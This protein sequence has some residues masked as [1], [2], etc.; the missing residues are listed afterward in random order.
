MEDFRNGKLIVVVDD[1][2]RENEGDL[3]V[4]A[5]HVTPAHVAFMIQYGRGPVH[6]SLEASRLDELGVVTG[7]NRRALHT[8]AGTVAIQARTALAAATGP[9]AQVATIQ[10]AL[11]PS[12]TPGDILSPGDVL[13]LRARPGGV[14]DR[15]GHTEVA[16]DLAKLAGVYPGG[17]LSTLGAAG[18]MNRL[19][20]LEAFAVEHGLTIISIAQVIAHRQRT[21]TLVERVAETK[22]PSRYGEF[23]MIAFKSV[24]DPDEHVALVM[25]DLS[26]DEPVLVRVHSEC[27]T[28]DAFGSLRCDCGEQMDLSLRRIAA[29][30]RGV[31]L[32]MRQE[33]RGIGLHNKIKAYALQ[34]QGLD[35]V[36]ANRALGFSA[37]P[38]QYGVGAQI[39]V[40]LGL[41]RIRLLTNNPKKRVGIE[42]YGLEVV[43][44]VPIIA[45]VTEHNRLYIETKRDKMGHDMGDASAQS[46]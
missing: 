37:D 8:A 5:Q 38:R 44:Q 34:D 7:Q 10:A 3:I 13:P 26:S 19:A 43:A 14:L 36:E 42:S 17:V 46:S 15:A 31:F 2:E 4:A 30:G 21:E 16:V 29:E 41:H 22:L 6:L 33:G 25:G 24:S 18:S 32:Y 12:T 9:E 27:L 35:T 45:P 1:E 40:D 39:L 28:G 20:Q 23:R 11:N